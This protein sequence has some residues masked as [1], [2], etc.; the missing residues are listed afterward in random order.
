M[1]RQ[2][3]GDYSR[4][5]SIQL[6]HIKQGSASFTCKEPG[7]QRFQLCRP[8]SLRLKYSTVCG[9]AEQLYT[10]HTQTTGHS[11]VLIKQ[12]LGRM[13]PNKLEFATP[14]IQGKTDVFMLYADHS[15]PKLLL[16]HL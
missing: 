9:R 6:H 7:S 5:A 8:L 14:G 4:M 16:H 13:W 15:T 1:G 2:R 12:A 10:R 3:G 11:C